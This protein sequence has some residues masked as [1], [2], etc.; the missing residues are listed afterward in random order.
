MNKNMFKSVLSAN[1]HNQNNLAEELK[2]SRSTLSK[3][4]NEKGS[5]FHQSEIMHMKRMY[6]LTDREIDLIFFS[7]KVS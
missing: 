3:K 4:V 6:N 1:G 5:E 2:I 7:E